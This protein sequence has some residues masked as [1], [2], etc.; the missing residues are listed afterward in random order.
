MLGFDYITP[1]GSATQSPVPIRII[2]VLPNV[3]FEFRFKLT[4]IEDIK[5]SA[6]KLKNIFKELILLFGAGAKTNV[7]YGVFTDEG[8]EQPKAPKSSKKGK[9]KKKEN[10]VQD[11]RPD[12][13]KKLS[14]AHF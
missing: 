7:G 8:V 1:H 2:K 9:K 12:W 6:G 3:Q 4:G 11:D 5:L 10:V 13:I 14:E